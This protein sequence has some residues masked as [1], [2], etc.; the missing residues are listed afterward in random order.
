MFKISIINNINQ[1][2]F[3][4]TFDTMEEANAW[5]AKQ[6]Q[7]AIQGLGWGYSARRILKSELPETHQS[8]VLSEEEVIDQEAYEKPIFKLDANDQPIM[9]EY[10]YYDLD[11]NLQIGLRPVVDHYETVPAVYVTYVNLDKEYTIDTQDI[12]AEYK[13]KKELDDL[14]ASGAKDE[15]CCKD[16]IRLIGGYNKKRSLSLAQVQSMIQT[17][18]TINELL[19]NNMPSTAKLTIQSIT[20][21]E[22]IT[23]EMIDL[24]MKVFERYEI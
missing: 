9:E 4:A 17:F 3:G 10:S 15:Q 19:K 20:P 18:A 8:L 16:V 21:D 1:R 6:E 7:K 23:Q 22:V 2:T 11:N 5:I 12:T 14:L 24:A 13:A